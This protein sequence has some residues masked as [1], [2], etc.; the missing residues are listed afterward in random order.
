MKI[1]INK[2]KDKMYNNDLNY[3]KPKT[4]NEATELLDNNGD[5]AL[6]AGGTDLLVEIKNGMREVC[7]LI[8]LN[9][10]SELKIISE[11]TD[12][13]YIGAGVT[14]SELISSELINHK[15]HALSE[16]ASKIGSHQIRN[17]GT[18]GGNLCTCA[19]CADTAPILLAYNSLVELVS[20]KTSRKVPLKEFFLFHHKTAIKKNEILT[21]VIVPKKKN[22]TTA[23]FEKF[24]IRNASNISVASSAVVLS[25]ESGICSDVNI[26]V[27]ACAPTPII[28]INANNIILNHK[29]EELLTNK[30]IIELAA[31]EAA[32][33]SFPINDIRGSANYRK[34]LVK[35][36]TRKA[37]TSALSRII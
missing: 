13:I 31:Q 9:E 25:F 33:G 20:Q 5:S 3:Y 30:E 10:L 17:V 16:A 26:A 24:G 22:V 32:N 19:S 14:H 6:I 8:S 29:I 27:G 23:S 11:D 36:L 2:E 4:I 28:S 15:L 12:N 7:K 34:H 21:R 1:I 37:L 18:I 35:V